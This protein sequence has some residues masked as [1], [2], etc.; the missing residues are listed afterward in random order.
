MIARRE[1]LALLASVSATIGHAV[2]LPK[3][4]DHRAGT[5][6]MVVLPLDN[7]VCLYH[8]AMFHMPMHAWQIIMLAKLD[9]KCQQALVDSEKAEPNTLYTIKPDSFVLQRQVTS[10]SPFKADLFK[11]HFEDEGG[12]KKAPKAA[13]F[14]A[15]GTITTTKLLR[16]QDL[17]PTPNDPAM[18]R[19]ML[20]GKNN[21]FYAIRLF[22]Q[23]RRT[24]TCADQIVK[25]SGAS[26]SN[27][28]S[29]QVVQTKSDD[30]LGPVDSLI[31][32]GTKFKTLE[33]YKDPSFQFNDLNG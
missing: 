8:L 22:S 29:G 28:T 19:W 25:L 14:L 16:N 24:G 11:F 5:H 33:I 20:V 3:G 1:F 10:A 23:P 9:A 27:L 12:G 2:S 17:S 18:G 13:K 6:G 15:R 30:P 31:V 32:N 21:T 7:E 26:F 4:F